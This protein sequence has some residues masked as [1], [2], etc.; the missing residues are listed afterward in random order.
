LSTHV[1]PCLVHAFLK[2][3]CINHSIFL[4]V[5]Y[6]LSTTITNNILFQSLPKQKV[7]KEVNVM[8]CS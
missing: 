3:H 5:G 8:L 2:L 6:L 1:L 4:L 7:I